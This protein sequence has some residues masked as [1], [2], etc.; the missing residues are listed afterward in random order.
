MSTTTKEHWEKI[1]REKRPDEVSWWQDN[2]KTSLEFIHS[3][4]LPRA[5]QIIDI[6]GGDS[7]FV[8]CLLA[9]GFE[10]ITVLDISE[11][12]IERAKARLGNSA[13]RIRWV[14]GDVIEF[15]SDKVFDVWHDRATFH[16]LTAEAAIDRYVSTVRGSVKPGGYLIIGTFS[17]M[18]PK[19]CSGLPVHQ[20]D[21]LSLNALLQSGFEKI[22]C[23]TEDHVT[24][25]GTKQNF[26]YCSFRR[27]LS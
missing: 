1:Y 21:E 26:L 23:F 24:P 17:S 14:V 5:A 13:Q 22:Q 8:D 4:K 15:T 6:G 19:T 16:F 25:F 9:E 3:F 27:H 20:Y 11:G 10:N 12:A 7:K 18:G 2:P